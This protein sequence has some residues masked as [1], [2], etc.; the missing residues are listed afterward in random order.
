MAKTLVDIDRALVEQAMA[1]LGEKTVAGAIRK[2]LR[3]V[4]AENAWGQ[5]VAH[6]GT[7]D[8]EQIAAVEEARNR[9]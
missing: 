5:L 8:D 6:L 2:A 9:W 1:V 4:V 7:W 3:R